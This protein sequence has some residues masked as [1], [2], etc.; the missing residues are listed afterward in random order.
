MLSLCYFEEGYIVEKQA[1]EIVGSEVQQFLSRTMEQ[2]L[3]QATYFA[4]DVKPVSHG[5]LL[6]FPC[7]CAA[8]SDT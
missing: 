6:L 3:L 5:F 1:L 2:D 4:M 8:H 7:R